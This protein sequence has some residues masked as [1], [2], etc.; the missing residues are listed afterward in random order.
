MTATSD[1]G[2]KD[3]PGQHTLTVEV[4]DQSGAFIPGAIVELRN[5]KNRP[6]IE[7]RTDPLGK[8][9]LPVDPGRYVAFV[10]SCGFM[11]FSQNLDLT[12]GSDQSVVAV[13]RVGESS[14]GG[15]PVESTE[16]QIEFQHLVPD[17]TIVAIPMEL[18]L[19]PAHKLRMH[20]R[21]L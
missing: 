4:K 1:Q 19:L 8:A 11:R 5:D 9:V 6:F 14:S 20:N 3:R 10:T 18:A 15:C 7:M 2:S 16:E 13:L 17:G 21:A 12:S